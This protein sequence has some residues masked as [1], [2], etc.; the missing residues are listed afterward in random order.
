MGSGD[1]CVALTGEERRTWNQD[2]GDASVPSPHHPNPRP[3]GDEGVSEGTSQWGPRVAHCARG[4]G[5]R[6]NGANPL[7]CSFHKNLPAK[8]DT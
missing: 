4:E 7:L 2:E 8:A 3:Y 6:R 1:A 5:D